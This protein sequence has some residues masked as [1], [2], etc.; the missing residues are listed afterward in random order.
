MKK[1]L[2]SVIVPVYKVEEYLK[3]CVDSIINQTYKNIEIIL[4]DDGSPDNCGKICDEYVKKDSRIKVIHKENGGLSSARNAGLDVAKGE[5]IAF[6]DSDDWLMPTYV[7]D[8]LKIAMKYNKE[9]VQCGHAKNVDDLYLKKE[10]SK[11]KELSFFEKNEAIYNLNVK[12]HGEY[13]VVWNKLYRKELF[14][15]IRFPVNRINEDTFVT[16]KLFWNC[17][18][19]IAFTRKKLYYY[20][21][22]EGSIMNNKF[23]I[24][25]YDALDGYQEQ[26][27]FFLKLKK[28]KLIDA[29]ICIYQMIIKDFWYRTNVADIENK[30]KYLNQLLKRSRK[31]YKYMILN[32]YISIKNKI[33]YSIF[34]ISPSMYFGIIKLFEKRT[35]K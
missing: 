16:Y 3:E 35:R 21:Q 14:E 34:D 20:R 11:D 7:Y 29:S 23:N 32:K 33:I 24:R 28:K 9:I 8:M 17:K 15:N 4:I 12:N 19:E 31:I 25:R 27:E 26:F 1:E 18:G 30:N 6:V 22:R 5:Y 13:I 10:L 2:V